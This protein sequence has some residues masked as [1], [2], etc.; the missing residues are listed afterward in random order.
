MQGAS[1]TTFSFTDLNITVG[2]DF[3]WIHEMLLRKV[4]VIGAF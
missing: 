3:Y 2:Q 4:K 1:L